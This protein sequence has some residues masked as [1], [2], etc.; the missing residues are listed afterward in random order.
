[1]PPD[2]NSGLGQF[3][4]AFQQ[5]A[6]GDVG[7]FFSGYRDMQGQIADTQVKQAEAQDLSARA[8][9]QRMINESQKKQAQM[10]QQLA[11]QRQQTLS[12]AES[13]VQFMFDASAMDFASGNIAAGSET[14]EKAMKVQ[15][16]LATVKREQD[17]LANQQFNQREKLLADE[18]NI[19]AGINS[20]ED[21]ARAAVE[22]TNSHRA[23]PGQ[24][25]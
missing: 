19:W 24:P 1:M 13:Q 16:Q 4:G 12:T 11:Q 18:D 23:V 21:Q 20:P 10:M 3:L 15:S 5:Q 9:H 8:E 22:W 2:P 6:G 17:Q 14:L 7:N 25:M